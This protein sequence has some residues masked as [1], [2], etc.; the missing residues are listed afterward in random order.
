MDLQ[1]VKSE[2]RIRI[3]SLQPTA[4]SSR[5]VLFNDFLESYGFLLK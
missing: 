2:T 4:Q 5:K 3:K 1:K